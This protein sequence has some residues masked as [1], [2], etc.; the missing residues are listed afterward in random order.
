[1]ESKLNLMLHQLGASRRIFELTIK[2]SLV[3]GECGREYE[4][5]IKRGEEKK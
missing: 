4:K 2:Y 1:M 5:G 3:E